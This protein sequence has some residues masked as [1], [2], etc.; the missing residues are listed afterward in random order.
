MLFKIKATKENG[1][2]LEGVR[3]A[4][5]K[6]TLSREMR[7]EGSSLFYAEALSTSPAHKKSWQNLFRSVALKDKIIFAS[8]LSSMISAGLTLSRSLEVLERQTEKK[9]FKSIIRDLLQ[10]VNMGESFS[11]ALAS[12]PEVFPPVF[13]SMVAAGEESGNLPKT[14]S[15]IKDQMG[16]T[17]DLRRKIIGAMIYPT[18]IV[19]LIFV[20]AVLML[21]FMVPTLSATFKDLNVELPLLTRIVIGTSDWLVQHFILFVSILLLIISGTIYWLRTPLGRKLS[22]RAIISL[23]IF[24]VLVKEYNSAIIMRTIS[25]LVSSGVSMT[26]SMTLTGKVVQNTLYRPVITKAAEDIQKG[27]LL[28]AV[29]SGN[30][31]LFPVLASEL[32]EVGEE[33]GDLPHM[34]EQGALFYEGEIDQATKNLSTIIEPLLMIVIGIAVGFF[35]Y[36]MI[37]PMYSL[38]SA[39]K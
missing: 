3:E 32:A 22:D 28:S 21:T 25:S 4:P 10:K 38:T 6:L 33:T 5:D 11:Q 36:A 1:E 17:Y 27:I 2:L 14:L 7:E 29:L 20:I 39:I 37:G 8:N 9:Y 12:F 19:I 13:S 31:K 23:P 24:G 34:L 30:E 18:I 15:L 26:G 35:V 16:K